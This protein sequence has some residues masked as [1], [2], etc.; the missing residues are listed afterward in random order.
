MGASKLF[1]W[2]ITAQRTLILSLFCCAVGVA[3]CEL[4]IPWL[5][6]NAIDAALGYRDGSRIDYIGAV[7]IAVICA[8]YVVHCVFLRIEARVMYE[9][10]FRLRQRL[11]TGL[12]SQ[13]LSFFNRARA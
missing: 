8:L 11:Y 12:L 3:A 1:F 13:R 7:M 6:Q 9:G 4:S 5:V 2:V 10:L